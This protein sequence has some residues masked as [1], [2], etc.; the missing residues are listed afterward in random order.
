MADS[1]QR[2]WRHAKT[3][4]FGQCRIIAR[5]VHCGLFWYVLSSFVIYTTHHHPFIKGTS[6][7][8]WYNDINVLQFGSLAN[9]SFVAQWKNNI[10]TPL[11]APIQPMFPDDDSLSSTQKIGIALA[12][13][14][15]V[16]LI[17]ILGSWYFG[18]PVKHLIGR[19]YYGIIWSIRYEIIIPVYVP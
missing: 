14:G 19:S 4:L 1:K 8:F 6:E 13:I 18:E 2:T 12:V 9:G 16:V 5:Q 17:I 3:T 10:T 7:Y 15:I 11:L